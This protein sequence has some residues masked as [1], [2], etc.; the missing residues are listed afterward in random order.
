MKS[1]SVRRKS[2][3]RKSKSVRRKSPRRKSKSIRRKSPQRKSRSVRRK[4][5][6]RK[7]KSKKLKLIKIVKSPIKTK[8]YTAYFSDGTHTNFGAAGMSDFTLHKNPLRKKR[9]I[10]RH[11]S[12]ENWDKPKTAGA[13][14]RWV[15]WNKPS[16]RASVSDY[17]KR[18][19]L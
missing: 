17:K 4:S 12:R 10:N 14:S 18:F 2:P 3:R 7:S 5:P 6:Q 19:K 9:Y 15:L 13:L 16:F 1:K 11:K 8:K